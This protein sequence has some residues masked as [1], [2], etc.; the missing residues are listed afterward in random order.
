MEF[1]AGQALHDKLKQLQDLLR[2][3]VPSG[4]L[5]AI[6]ERAVDLLIVDTMKKFV[7][8]AKTLPVVG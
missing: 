2:H 8:Q 5:A 7:E 4:D 3:Q 6:V 1:T